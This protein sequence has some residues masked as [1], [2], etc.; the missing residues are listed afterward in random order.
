MKQ[1]WIN[2]KDLISR[3][4]EKD[5]FLDYCLINSSKV[6][7]PHTIANLFNDY[8]NKMGSSPASNMNIPLNVNFQNYLTNSVK[9]NLQLELCYGAP[10]SP[11][12][13]S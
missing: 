13:L 6:S 12:I 4:M 11:Q 5:K 8:F 10:S 9:Q 2:M 3:T 7:D 1:T